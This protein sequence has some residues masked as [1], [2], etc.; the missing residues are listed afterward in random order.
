MSTYLNSPGIVTR[1]VSTSQIRKQ[2]ITVGAAIIGPTVKGPVNIPTILTS[3]SEY[4]NTFGDT[5]VFYGPEGSQNTTYLT[6]VS[7]ENYFNSGGGSLLVTRVVSGSFTGAT[8]TP[9]LNTVVMGTSIEV[10]TNTSL[11]SSITTYPTGVEFN[12]SFNVI[13]TGGSGTGLTLQYTPSRT[14]VYDRINRRYTFV[15][16]YKINVTAPGE[17]YQAGDT[18]TIPGVQLGLNADGRLVAG[19]NN[20][21]QSIDLWFESYNISPGRGGGLTGRGY[22]GKVG[23][24]Y[25]NGAVKYE[26]VR[27]GTTGSTFTNLEIMSP[28]DVRDDYDNNFNI[29]E[30][31]QLW[32]GRD[33]T[34]QST[35]YVYYT[36]T[37]NNF[38]PHTPLVITLQAGDITTQTGDVAFELE[39]LS[40]G[41]LM[42]NNGPEVEGALAFGNSGNIRWEIPTVNTSSGEFSLLI[43][44]GDD[45][46]N[47]KVVLETYP[48]LSL[49]PKSPNY[50][51]KIIGDQTQIIATEGTDTY[52]ETTGEYANKSNYVRVKSTAYKTPEYLGNTGTPSNLYKTYIPVVQSGAFAGASGAE[53]PNANATFYKDIIEDANFTSQGVPAASYASAIALLANKND[54]DYNVITVPGLTYD[55][56]NHTATLNTLIQNTENRGD[57]IAIVDTVN[58]GSTVDNVKSKAA[59]VNSSYASTYWPW[60]NIQDPSTG[61]IIEVPPS[62]L[63]PGVYAYT[64]KVS[65]PWFAPAGIKRGILGNAAIGERKLAQSTRDDLYSNKVNPIAFINR[66]GTVVYGQKTLQTRASALDRVNVRRLLIELKRYLEQ[67]A[68]N[69][70]FDQNSTVTRNSF[71]SNVTPYLENIQ[72]NQGIYAFKVIMDDTNNTPDVID[73]NELIGQF[74][75]Q[76]TKTAEFIY[77]DFN[78]TPTGVAFPA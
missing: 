15:Q 41:R 5:F 49:D 58:Y 10:G 44:R 73:R 19:Q 6:S 33:A 40:K 34:T 75:I 29:G 72:Q 2:P 54:Y 7:A 61:L 20:L 76:P 59:T 32:V 21:S 71:L 9:I 42:N 12:Q 55:N 43:R 1:E 28:P 53:S 65:A 13:P 25:G 50:I 68:T 57:A 26:V 45:S 48:K 31:Y 62:T 63:L 14:S 16:D 23:S 27:V 38:T 51:N 3:Y 17:S 36:L 69:L 18:I 47:K 52:L 64:D 4:V 46:T 67:L 8:S 77:L 24:A 39:T 70:V 56:P 60:L 37:S 74:Y 35:R 30:R 66:T 78:I 22:S 11:S